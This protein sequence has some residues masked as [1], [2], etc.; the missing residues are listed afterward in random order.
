MRVLAVP[1]LLDPVERD[2]LDLYGQ[3]TGQRV[4]AHRRES[5]AFALSRRLEVGVADDA[6][7]LVA[8]S[9]RRQLDRLLRGVADLDQAALDI[10]APERGQRRL[11][12]EGIDDHVEA[13]AARLLELLCQVS[14]SAEIDDGVGAELTVSAVQ[15]GGVPSRGDDPAGARPAPRPDR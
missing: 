11:P 4:L 8:K 9:P 14:L 13:P 1:G 10:Q 3:L 7:E 6:A 2:L 12:P 15:A 5:L